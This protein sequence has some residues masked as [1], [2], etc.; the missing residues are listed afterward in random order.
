MDGPNV[1][2][3]F[4]D[5]F[6]ASLTETVNHFLIKIGTCSLLVVHD[7]FKNGEALTQWGLKKY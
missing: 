1:S 5:K 7:S 2:F 6:G 4:Y 3:T